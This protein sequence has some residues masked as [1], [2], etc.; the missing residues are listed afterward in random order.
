[1][2]WRTATSLLVGLTGFR[3]S[4]SFGFGGMQQRV[5]LPETLAAIRSS[6]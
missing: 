4:L 2:E 6:F 3:A 5:T 1:M